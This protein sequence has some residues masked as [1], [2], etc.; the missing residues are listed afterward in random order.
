MILNEYN[1]IINEYFD[2][3]DRKTRKTIIALEDAQQNQML[4]ALA[5]ALYDKVVEKVDQIDFGTIPKSRGDI[6]KV[7]GF[8]NTV[9]CL[10]IMRSMV[11][12]YK[13]NTEI[14]DT[15]LT[16]IN[17]IKQSKNLFMKAFS[18]NAEF[19]ITLYNLLVMAI[20]QSV[21]FL[22]AVTIQYI[23][24]PSS[25]N[26]EVALDKAA[27]NNARDNMLYEQLYNF[28]KSYASG[29]VDEILREVIKNGGKLKESVDVSG[30]DDPEAG[31]NTININVGGGQAGSN[32][33]IK[34][35]RP[36][37]INNDAIKDVAMARG[38][39]SDDDE[40]ES[41]PTP[42]MAVNGGTDITAPGSDMEVTQPVEEVAITAGTVAA[43]IA[44]GAGG[45]AAAFKGIKW[46]IKVMIPMMRNI[47]YFVINSI[48]SFSDSLAVQAQFIE[49]N[50]YK[51][52]YSTNSNLDEEKKKKVV[53]KQLKI[54][55]KLKAI[56]SKFA[57]ND[58]KAKK[59]AK[60]MIEDE[61]KKKSTIDDLKDRL[62]DDIS[63]DDLF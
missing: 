53:E 57:I 20:E 63:S 51:L 49:L 23:K 3:H 37:F 8:D 4:A 27:Y 59:N 39:Y 7:D 9:E 42:T 28:N 38:N 54:A 56:S 2:I 32:F 60:K 16:S 15:V 44:L 33:K 19:G 34:P 52:Q 21:S 11:V 22:I 58:K 25:Q 40:V 47:T 50:A 55:S 30:I 48:V 6:T 1:Q 43:I 24:D 26:Y 5:S 36:P 14:V 29:E 62:P 13:E 46:L 41:E 45:V 18:L 12:E 17:N 31:V 61:K 35:H 10:N